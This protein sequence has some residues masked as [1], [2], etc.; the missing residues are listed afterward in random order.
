MSKATTCEWALL[1][2]DPN[3]SSHDI[4]LKRLDGLKKRLAKDPNLHKRYFEQMHCM[5]D[6]GY[7]E[8]VSDQELEAP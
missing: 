4:A 1:T 3:A 6:S 5:I 8:K 7:A 2:A